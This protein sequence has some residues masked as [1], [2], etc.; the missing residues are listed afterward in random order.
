MELSVGSI[1]R[2]KAL[3]VG[4]GRMA[5]RNESVAVVKP[6]SARVE[7]QGILVAGREDEEGS[8]PDDYRQ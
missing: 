6:A 4:L 8:E 2:P 5:G 3:A 7:Y 1:P